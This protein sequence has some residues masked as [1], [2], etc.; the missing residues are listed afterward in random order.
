MICLYFLWVTL[1]DS[2]KLKNILPRILKPWSESPL[3]EFD[4]IDSTN[5]YAMRLIDV[6]EAPSGTAILTRTQTAGKGQRGRIWEDEPG[7]S[8][9]MSLIVA[10]RTSLPKAFLFSA[11]VALALTDLLRS[12]NPAWAV[13]IKWPNDLIVNDKKAG[14]ILIENQ[15]RGQEWLR[16]VVG[17]GLNVKQRCFPPHLLAATSL[18]LEGKEVGDPWD[19]VPAIRES[20][21]RRLE[22]PEPDEKVLRTYNERLYAR[23]QRRLFWEGG[24]RL[25][26]RVMEVNP[27][28][29]LALDVDGQ[30]RWFDHGSLTWIRP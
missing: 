28:G 5:N 21:Q 12:M 4:S 14:G 10:P 8:L 25:E 19:L 17:L 9:L 7:S 3:I 20:M 23:G 30:R 18:F 26:G 11:S 29:Q 16:S 27:Q 15:I 22:G 24:H 2:S 6:N 1:S 13:R